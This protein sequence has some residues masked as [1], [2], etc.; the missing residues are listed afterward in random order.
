MNNVF[1]IIIAGGISTVL[2]RSIGLNPISIEGF[3]FFMIV[4]IFISFVIHMFFSKKNIEESKE[5]KLENKR[6][7]KYLL[8]LVK[9][10]TFVFLSAIVL[11]T[12]LNFLSYKLG[13]FDEEFKYRHDTSSAV[14]LTLDEKYQTSFLFKGARYFLYE[15]NDKYYLVQVNDSLAKKRVLSL[16]SNI[17][18]S[19]IYDKLKD[20]ENFEDILKNISPS[21]YK[22]VS[23]VEMIFYPLYLSNNTSDIYWN[24]EEYHRYQ[25]K[26]KSYIKKKEDKKRKEILAKKR[27]EYKKLLNKD[28]H[29]LDVKQLESLIKELYP[30][31]AFTIDT[32]HILNIFSQLNKKNKDLLVYQFRLISFL[33]LFK[34]KELLNKILK[35]YSMGVIYTFNFW[36]KTP[37]DIKKQDESHLRFV[38]LSKNN[39]FLLSENKIKSI[40]FVKEELI[41]DYKDKKNIVFSNF[42][43]KDGEIIKN[44][45]RS[46]IQNISF[47]EKELYKVRAYN[48][49]NDKARIEKN[50]LF[51]N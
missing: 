41:L 34:Q 27:E 45:L 25:A 14:A 40:S 24:S 3:A 43:N 30:Y 4:F 18:M 47:I 17:Y 13:A 12:S 46:L 32:R 19:V 23:L 8:S 48:K 5:V 10:F 16:H 44:K 50:E 38:D 9:K 42:K 51:I 31:Y 22:E 36:D 2:Q 1:R 33:H 20:E 7:N 26:F 29:K 11:N 49:K 28:I 15:S 6:A 35:K 21:V 37:L 39:R